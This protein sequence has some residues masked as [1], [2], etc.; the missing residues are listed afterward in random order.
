MSAREA[1][2]SRTPGVPG[3][4]VDAPGQQDADGRPAVHVEGAPV[5]T[6]EVA[7]LL[8]ADPAG[9]PRAEVVE[10]PSPERVRRPA[11]LLRLVV[12]V[13]VLVVVI[14]LADLAV[15]T[16]GA[17]EQDLSLATTGA[18]RLLLQ[19]VSWVAGLAVV[20]LPLVIG[21]DLLRRSRPRQLVEALV[22]AGVGALLVLALRTLVLEGHV[23]SLLSALTRPTVDGRS[24]PADAVLVSLTALITVADV[25]GRRWVQ[26]TA[27]VI[28]VS[29]AVTTFASG[30]STGLAVVVSLLLGWSVGLAVRYG[31]GAVPTRPPGSDV[32]LALQGAGLEVRR[33]LLEDPD[34]SGERSYRAVTPTGE[35]DVQVLDRDTF[36]FATGRR[37]W[38]MLRLRG[39][40]TRAP[41]LNLRAEVEH[42]A[43]VAL[44]LA[45]AGVRAPRALAVCEVGPFSACLAYT[46]PQGRTLAEVGE[47]LTDDELAAVW[48]LLAT[49]RRRRLAHRGLGPDVVMVAHGDD[50]APYGV[51]RRVGGGDVAA[52]DLALRIDA[53]QLLVTVALAAGAERTVRTA[54]ARLGEDAVVSAL[55]L[56]QPIVFTTSTRAALR[57]DKELLGRLRDEITRVRPQAEQVEPLQL[58][59]VTG[60]GVVTV[61]GLGVAGY[62]I[63]T[64]LA[65]VD[66]GRVVSE[67]RWTWAVATVVAA[68]LTFAGAST[69]LAGSVTIRL[70]FVRTYMTQLAV[71]FSGLVAPAV[72]GNLALN[73]RFLLRSGVA[74]GVAAASVGLAQVAQFCSY[75]ILLLVSGVLAGTGPRAS[76]TPPAALVA[77]I[78]VVVL[79]VLALLAVPKVRKAI[80]SRVLPQVR[81]VVPQV[82]GVFQH[83]GKVAQLLGGAMLLDTSFVASLVCATRAFGAEPPVAAVAVVYFAGAIIGSAVP[84]PGGLG[85]IEAAISAGLIAIG[86]DSGTAVSSVLLYR[87]ATYW[88]PIP[89]G[90]FA[91][92]RLT[93]WQAI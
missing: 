84:T 41:A 88:L 75:V 82:L 13:A 44:A 61:A 74:P 38:R 35:L 26:P 19:V 49:L 58:R 80:A 54:I 39:A 71:A 14:A 16:A 59:R 50:G 47:A 2:A 83:P 4:A 45:D 90:W 42:R 72:I 25:G 60:R 40:S 69:V 91:L 81:A 20:L 63:L 18:P 56:L 15:G 67:A 85:G 68:A 31:L 6:P 79:V 77:A 17:L 43:L 9:H 34:D 53:A 37:F 55:P 7:A 78:P 86:V 8:A 22:A 28:I 92:N 51:L 5:V 36:G 89:F 52:A 57:R 76:F 21:A 12:S 46:D 32:A 93:T 73:T 24:S 1:P 70:S 10:P 3:R 29:S 11:D 65:K 30:Q 66:V 27:A 62:F 64:Q 48:E 33:L 87:L 23:A